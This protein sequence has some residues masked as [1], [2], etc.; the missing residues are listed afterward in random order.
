MVV[1]GKTL[2]VDLSAH[3]DGANN[4]YYA[5]A[6]DYCH[7]RLRMTVNCS[8]LGYSAIAATIAEVTAG[9]YGAGDVIIT[10][11]DTPTTSSPALVG[12]SVSVVIEGVTVNTDVSAYSSDLSGAAAAVASDI[13]A[14]AA[15][16][17]LDYSATADASNPGDII[18]SRANTPIT[19]AYVAAVPA[20][21]AM[22]LTSGD[23]ARTA[24]AK[25]DTAIKTVNIQRSKLGAVS[26]RLS[27]TVNNLTN[28][29]SNLSAAQG[30]IEDADFAKETTDLAKNQI[31]QQAS[32][33]MLAQ[34]NASKQNVLS[35]LQG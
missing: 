15:L 20:T 13:N 21:T 11:A 3:H 24:T 10:R 33:A 35:L 22:S 17:A 14:D 6:E 1:N 34:A 4:D 26:N 25:I 19:Q 16:Q 29:S 5:A 27:H 30:G 8:A 31:L 28:I 12:T 9:T 32:T 7:Q 23:S 2:T 18:I